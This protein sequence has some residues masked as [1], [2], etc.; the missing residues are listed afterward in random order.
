MFLYLEF[1]RYCFTPNFAVPA[2]LF[3]SVDG[4]E[5]IRFKLKNSLLPSLKTLQS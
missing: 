1:V 2:V 5:P 4:S 3:N